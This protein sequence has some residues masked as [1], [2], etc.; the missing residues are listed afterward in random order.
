MLDNKI[1]EQVSEFNHLGYFISGHTVHTRF[2]SCL[3][4]WISVLSF[5][6]VFLSVLKLM[7][8]VTGYPYRVFSWCSSVS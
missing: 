5:L 4:Y 8:L 6:V 7:L 3:S 1:I 2:E